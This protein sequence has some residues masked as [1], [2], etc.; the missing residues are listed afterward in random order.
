L[1]IL[2]DEIY[3]AMIIVIAA[4][5]LFAPFALRALYSVGQSEEAKT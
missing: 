3:A 1:Y 4:T 5:T 2:N